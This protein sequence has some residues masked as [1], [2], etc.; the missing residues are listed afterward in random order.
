MSPIIREHL[1]D[2]CQVEVVRPAYRPQCS[3]QP[4][5]TIVEVIV[6]RAQIRIRPRRRSYSLPFQCGQGLEGLVF[7]QEHAS[8]I[9]LRGRAGRVGSAARDELLLGFRVILISPVELSQLK[10]RAPVLG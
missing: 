6:G 1:R 3:G 9:Q 2:G 10:V 8:Q 7:E 5:G 4:P